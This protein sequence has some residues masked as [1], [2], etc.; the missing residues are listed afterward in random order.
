MLIEKEA[1][2]KLK[3]ELG[4]IQ[5]ANEAARAKIVDAR[6]EFQVLIFNV[7]AI[8]LFYSFSNWYVGRRSN[9]R[10]RYLRFLHVVALTVSSR[11]KSS[12]P[13]KTCE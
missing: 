2:K 9:L 1:A 7:S 8:C 3:R 5:A 10:L 6:N 11:Y 12:G 4:E 13:T